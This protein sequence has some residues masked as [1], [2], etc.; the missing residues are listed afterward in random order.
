MRGVQGLEVGHQGPHS[1]GRRGKGGEV[2]L[3]NEQPDRPLVER[4]TG[5][6]PAGRRVQQR[7]RVGGVAG[8][9][10]DG[11]PAPAQIDGV[12]VLDEPGRAVRT[13]PIT[14]GVEARRQVAAE[15]PRRHLALDPLVGKAARVGPRVVGVHGQEAM[16]IGVAADMVEMGVG[17][18]DRHGKAGELF[19]DARD[20]ADA[21][22]GV[23]E[24][25]APG[26][27][28][29]VGYHFLELVRLADREHAVA[30]FVD[31]EPVVGQ[32]HARETRVARSWEKI[33]PAGR[34]SRFPGHR[35]HA[36]GDQERQPPWGVQGGNQSGSFLNAQQQ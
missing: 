32:V 6:E 23:E 9:V 16:E 11:E 25:R 27:E 2:G 14:R 28:D 20:S 31:H 33:T 30:D 13:G 4:V 24:E 12:P 17:V 35:Q 1:I 7:H 21:E 5:E 10:Q 34:G 36:C 22:P 3:G 15:G 8:H 29:E 18:Q 26:A 19:H